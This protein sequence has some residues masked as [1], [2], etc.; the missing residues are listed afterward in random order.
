MEYRE[1]VDYDNERLV[2]S[3][4]KVTELLKANQILRDQMEKL[5]KGNDNKD[6]EVYS[7][8]S[9]NIN[10]REKIE[11]LEQIIK[12]NRA[13][14]DNLVSAKVLSNMEKSTYEYH[15]G[16]KGKGNTIDVVYVELIEL[17]EHNRVLEKRVKALEK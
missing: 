6:N 17:R 8:T 5:Q 13:E 7:I 14:Y 16:G 3:V 1:K 11:I 12:S 4:S 15:G 9:E 2:E 10:L